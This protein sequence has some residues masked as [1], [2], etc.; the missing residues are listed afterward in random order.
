MT[1]PTSTA[2]LS[3]GKAEAVF[4]EILGGDTTLCS[5][6]QIQTKCGIGEAGLRVH[7]NLDKQSILDQV[8]A[9]LQR[10]RSDWVDTLLLHRPEP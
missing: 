7:Y 4:G 10:L 6:I 5:S 3:S 1:T 8:Q 9:S 2:Q